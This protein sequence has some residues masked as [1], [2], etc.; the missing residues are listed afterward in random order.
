MEKGKRK[1]PVYP[2]IKTVSLENRWRTLSTV[3]ANMKMDPRK[4]GNGSPQIR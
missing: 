3:S 2:G 4:Y 1:I